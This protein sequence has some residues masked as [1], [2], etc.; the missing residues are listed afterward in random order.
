[1]IRLYVIEDNVTIIIPGLKNLF[2][3]KRDGIK[4]IGFSPT[5][6]EAIDNADPG[7]VDLFVLDLY[8]YG[9][10]PIENFRKLK[11]NFPDK[12]IAIY[13]SEKASSWRKRMMDEGALTYITKDSPRDEL[14][15]ALIKAASGEIYYFGQ[16]EMDEKSNNENSQ[17]S[18]LHNITPGQQ[19][20]IMLLSEGLLHNEIAERC[21]MS[22]SMLEKNLNHLRES[23]GVRN[24]IELVKLFM[25]S[26]L[27]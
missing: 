3:P 9:S 18:E 22:R 11:T 6:D 8:I 13:T 17:G 12:P 24:N 23:H 10:L 4:V 21:D 16:K 20:M 5:V 26:G 27:I 25:D 19:K 1:M 14:K 15:S 2:R 7:V